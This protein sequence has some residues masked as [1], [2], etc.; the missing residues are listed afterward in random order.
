MPA[1]DSTLARCEPQTTIREI[2]VSERHT[3]STTSTEALF[4]SICAQAGY[5]HNRDGLETGE[6][7][8]EV[9]P[10]LIGYGFTPEHLFSATFYSWA[11]ISMA[12]QHLMLHPITWRQWC[13]RFMFTAAEVETGVDKGHPIMMRHQQAARKWCK[14][15][16]VY[17]WVECLR[18]PIITPMSKW[19]TAIRAARI[20][21]ACCVVCDATPE[22]VRSVS[23]SRVVVM[24]RTLF[25]VAIRTLTCQSFPEIALMLGRHCHSTH[26]EQHQ[27]FTA[28]W[29]G[30]EPIRDAATLQDYAE[31]WEALMDKL[32]LPVTLQPKLNETEMR[33]V[34]LPVEQRGAA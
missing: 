31:A 11:Q 17:P 23:R 16:R 33:R 5:L 27:N 19:P 4:T 12:K 13:N 26:I 8:I 28:L 25:T 6:G 2:T 29:M 18:S 34:S 24:C 3:V 1:L 10:Y 22:R 32:G 20:L 7:C 14:F 30:G 9:L 15:A 21:D